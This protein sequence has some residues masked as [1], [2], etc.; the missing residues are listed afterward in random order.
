MKSA[1]R[2]NSV[3]WK[4]LAVYFVL[5]FVLA[6]IGVLVVSHQNQTLTRERLEHELFAVIHG[7][8]PTLYAPLSSQPRRTESIDEHIAY[9]QRQTGIRITVTDPQGEVLS[10]S[11]SSPSSME[12][13]SA[14]IEFTQAAVQG[15]GHATR[16]S[17]TTGTEYQYLAVPIKIDSKVLG[18]LRAAVP[19]A[20]IRSQLWQLTLV[21]VWLAAIS[22][23]VVTAIMFVLSRTLSL[24]LIEL[25]EFAEAVSKGDYKHPLS[26]V[27]GHSV[28]SPLAIGFDRM[29]AELER[30]ERELIANNER[31]E[32]VLMSLNEGVLSIDESR[33]VTLANQASIQLLELPP[34]DYLRSPLYKLVCNP[35]VE[36]GVESVFKTR[37]QFTREFESNL[38]TRRTLAMRAT[39]LAQNTG[40]SVVIVL[41]DVTNMRQLETMRRDF[42][43]NVSHELKTPLSSIKAYAET[44]RLGAIND[45]ANRLGFVRRIEEQANR[46][47]DIILDLIKLARIESGQSA[48]EI[49]DVDMV[50]VA[51]QRVGA[52]EEAAHMRQIT[53]NLE[54]SQPAV[55]VRADEEGVATI[56]D[57]LISNAVRYTPEGGKVDVRVWADS[58]VGVLDVI[59]N[60]I[61]IASEFH[62]RIFERFYRVDKARSSDLGGTGLG[63]SIVKHLTQ[64]FSGSVQLSSQIGH[65]CRF[66][67]K[68]PLS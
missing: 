26:R 52:F 5:Q 32:A 46:L 22:A 4:L 37:Q 6:A 13:H 42:V 43:A 15:T 10:D 54:S 30:R 61:G 66:T 64:S 59:D 45:K 60:G 47:H 24:P 68:L 18:Y 50:Q 56:L 41:H 51:A 33:R 27:S 16:R 67:V 44:L 21:A 65:G 1:I 12:N 58:S 62:E 40:N 36:Q 39:R 9:L 29:Q 38:S 19:T 53:L 55:I 14:R 48:L 20:P 7:L 23:L 11:S 49:E 17:E 2:F 8:V 31:L 63:L 35:V 3:L 57:N 25:V 28:W 34:R